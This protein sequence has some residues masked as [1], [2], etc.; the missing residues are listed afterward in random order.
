MRPQIAAVVGEGTGSVFPTFDATKL[1]WIVGEKSP[2][3][4]HSFSVRLAVHH[5][6]TAL[7]DRVRDK[8]A[9]DA[10]RFNTNQRKF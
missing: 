7:S 1:Q 3:F 4:A 5:Y 8:F 6:S 9:F 10:L 2:S